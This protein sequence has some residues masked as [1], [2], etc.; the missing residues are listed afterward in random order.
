MG[1]D[2]ISIAGLYDDVVTSYRPEVVCLLGI[3]SPS[4]LDRHGKISNRVDWIPLGPA[5]LGVD[6][7]AGQRGEDRLPPA[8]TVLQLDAEDKVVEQTGPI[9]TRPP[10]LRIW[11]DEIE[12]VSLPQQFS[13]MTWDF[14]RGG[15]AGDPFAPEGKVYDDRINH[16]ALYVTPK[17]CLYIFRTKMAWIAA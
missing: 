2:G 4:I 14:L 11:A 6:D 13:S 9:E 17:M 3:E 12:G 1:K 10:R 5:V 8:E 15:F 16:G 7:S